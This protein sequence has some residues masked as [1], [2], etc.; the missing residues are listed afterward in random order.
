MRNRLIVL[1]LFSLLGFLSCSPVDRFSEYDGV[2]LIES[3]S[4]DEWTPDFNDP[5]PYM[6]YESAGSI[7]PDGQE[8]FRLR[9]QNLF[10]N[11]D[12]ETG[13]ALGWVLTTYG[14][15]SIINSGNNITGCS[16][17]YNTNSSTDYIT[18]PLSN[19]TDGFPAKQS[20]TFRF[21]LKYI[22]AGSTLIF[23]FNTNPS[24]DKTYLLSLQPQTT[25]VFYQY[26]KDF[27]DS[28]LIQSVYSD[29]QNRFF[30][31]NTVVEGANPAPQNGVIDDIRFLRSD[32]EYK[33][34][35]I[36]DRNNPDRL[37]LPSGS[38]RFSFYV[39]QDPA[40]GS[41]NVFP[42]TRISFGIGS[43]KKTVAAEA[44]WTSW[45]QVSAVFNNLQ[46]DPGSTMELWISATDSSSDAYRDC[47]SIL[48]ST[49]VLEFLPDQ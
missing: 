8:A 47:G 23:D 38:Y 7:G 46:I 41:N 45:T 6:L 48:I 32:L 44:S 27:P 11:G 42:A 21:N 2:N 33:V 20:Y 10:P 9:T 19:L 36:L 18:Y 49:P 12:F 14:S 22:E 25:K 40:A 39:K 26:P 31:L 43:A 30:F 13:M 17:R 5:S 16:L 35:I 24:T 37:S 29:E 3:V 15:L 34:R 28:P 1:G 4:L